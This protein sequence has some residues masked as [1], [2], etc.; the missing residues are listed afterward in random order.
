MSWLIKN[1][2]KFSE[3]KA[4]TDFQKDYTY[5]EIIKQIEIYD[6]F[7]KNDIQEGEVVAIISDY[8]FYSISLFLI[9]FKKKCIIV[10]VVSKIIEQTNQKIKIAMV[11]KIINISSTGVL[12]INKNEIKNKNTLVNKIQKQKSSGLILFSSGSAGNPKAMIHN[13]DNLVDSFKEK[14]VR[15]LNILVFLLFDHIGGL[16]TMLNALS[17]GAHLVLPINRNAESIAALI[18][19]HKINILPTSPTFLNMMLIENVV[20]KFDLSS[21]K[22]ITYG[23]E[24]MQKSILM[25]LKKT[26]PKTRLLQTFGTSETGIAQTESFSSESLKIKIKDPNQE[27]KIVNNEL[28]LRSKTQVLG[29]L[30]AKMDN[31]TADGWFKTGDIVE[32]TQDGYILVVGRKKEIINVGGE[33]VHP[34]EIE[35]VL[36]EMPEIEDCAAYSVKNVITGQSVAVKIVLKKNIDISRVKKIVRDY[37]KKRIENYKVPTKINVVDKIEFTERFKKNRKNN[38]DIKI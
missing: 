4:I 18:Q 30:N 24:Q 35:T 34:S 15:N 27:I 32:D 26:F 17:I 23:T 6:N 8:N 11:E 9:L 36:L 2:A 10:P 14:K 19:K 38:A 3:K 21:L 12:S 25:K 37:C 33:K 22:M 20:E 16:N 31:F 5:F 7:L 13:L 1:L 29:Y 28:W